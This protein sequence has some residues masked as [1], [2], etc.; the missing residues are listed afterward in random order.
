MNKVNKLHRP[1]LAYPPNTEP[2]TP[3]NIMWD[4]MQHDADEKFYI[5]WS[6]EELS[7]APA[8][9]LF[10]PYSIGA[11][12]RKWTVYFGRMAKFE[13]DTKKE[14]LKA[15]EEQFRTG[16][17]AGILWHQHFRNINLNLFAVLE[18]PD[19]TEQQ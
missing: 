12:K 13:Y 1:E 10:N 2:P 14:A 9:L 4:I 11:L 18:T 15:I 19:L 8:W 17:Q 16:K 7:P 3:E 6:G 5:Q